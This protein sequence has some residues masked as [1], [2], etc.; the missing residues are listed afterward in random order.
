MG[1][2]L[3]PL[4]GKFDN[5]G[6][7]GAT[8]N[9]SYVTLSTDSTLPNE[10]V[11]TGTTNQITITDNGAGSTV[12]LSTPQNIH[13]AATPTFSNLTLSART[14][15]RVP[16]FTTGGEITDNAK[17]RFNGT[18]LGINATSVIP[19]SLCVGGDNGTSPS[20]EVA[21]GG[22]SVVLQSYNR[23]TTAYGTVNLV[24]STCIFQ[25]GATPVTVGS[26]DANGRFGVPITGVNAG[27]LIG[28]DAQLFRGAANR[29]DLA[30]GDSFYIIQSGG[31]LSVG[32]TPNTNHAGNFAITTNANTT[33]R[34]INADNTI[35]ASVTS[36]FP[37][38][39]RFGISLNA[40]ANT[41]SYSAG[42][43]FSNRSE[44]TQSGTVTEAYGAD[45]DL[46]H[47]G[48]A[49]YTVFSGARAFVSIRNTSSN[50]IAEASGFRLVLDTQ[51]GGTNA[52]ITTF[53]GF[54]LSAS[55]LGP[56]A[57]TNYSAFDAALSSG[58]GSGTIANYRAFNADNPG[59][60]AT[61]TTLVGM[62]IADLTR[63]VINY[64]ILFEGTSGL[65]RQGVWWNADTV[66]FRKAAN[67]LGIGSGDSVEF[68]AGNIITDTVTGTKIGTATTQKLGF[69]NAT[70][71]VQPTTSVAAATFVANTSGIVNDTATFDGY[72]IGQIVKALRN[73]GVL[74]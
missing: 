63:G 33:F 21:T 23:N 31:G 48:S 74:A 25:T 52:N 1:I 15:T 53:R 22:T 40:G 60:N 65:E 57:I 37:V 17:L 24:G 39:G 44:T 54:S 61:I 35:T 13:T 71:I 6:P 42:V 12:I 30:T 51:S 45:F 38:G 43:T 70:P 16:Y 10:R 14:T 11:L 9:A 20:F 8:P 5:T 67:T 2:T 4:S 26:F 50:T 36:A 32:T 68:N 73:I 18:G 41:I 27:I 55:H 46:W 66:I 49:N 56:C 64:G 34:A 28:G 29:L 19:N 3:N 69:W 59:A 58:V 7:K 72:T 47:R 62:R